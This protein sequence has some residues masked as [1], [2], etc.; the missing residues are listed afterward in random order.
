MLVARSSRSSR[1][2]VAAAAAA[3]ASI[4]FGAVPAAVHAVVVP[5]R[6]NQNSVHIRELGCLRDSET[7]LFSY[8]N[9]NI[10]H[11][12]QCAGECLSLGFDTSGTEAGA[13]CWCAHSADLGDLPMIHESECSTP[14]VDRPSVNC[15]GQWALSAYR[16]PDEPTGTTPAIMGTPTAKPPVS[17]SYSP[18][19][20]STSQDESSTTTTPSP[21]LTIEYLGCVR[22]FDSRVFPI[23]TIF[24]L[25]P[26]D[27][28]D[29]CF[30]LGYDL[31]GT[32]VGHECFCAESSPKTKL[33]FISPDKCDYQCAADPSLMCG[34]T[35]AL[36]VYRHSGTPPPDPRAPGFAL[37][38]ESFY[39]GCLR[40]SA[41]RFLPHESP[42]RNLLPLQCV[43]D[44]FLHDFDIS[45][46]EAGGE[47]WC[48][49]SWELGD[50]PRIDE[51]ECSTPCLDAQD[52]KCGGQWAL[53]AYLWSNK[54]AG[55][56]PAITGTP[57]PTTAVEY[58]GCFRDY[59]SRVFPVQSSFEVTPSQCTELC[60]SMG[61]DL[62]GTEAARECYCAT[63]PPSGSELRLLS[64]DNCN[65]AC[66]AD[67]SIMCGGSWAL[68]VFRHFGTPPDPRKP[69]SADPS[70][71]F[72]ISCLRDSAT[73]LFPFQSPNFHL[74]PLQCV[75]DCASRGFD[76]S[77][78]EAGLECWC[79]KVVELPD[80]PVI[81]ESECSTPCLEE[82]DI[83]CGGQWALAA[84]FFDGLESA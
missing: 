15:G 29:E 76:T 73:R 31:S 3:A 66:W 18:A 6:R 13:E 81:D 9:P 22:D 20:T 75:A 45:G 58:L 69:E 2:A 55:T 63:S 10:L 42:N 74:N 83:T 53:S 16:V 40:D 49:H 61:Y 44:C 41:T 70:R 48:A 11:P 62:S 51:S 5:P 80:F 19:P 27:C 1:L 17:S 64:P 7:R 82:R 65:Y 32:E 52:I 37:K 4:F 56:T 14:C 38:S 25:S 72:Y 67:P 35:W 26:S 59:Y 21:T 43:A 78:T 23:Q 28:A 71:S 36:S 60:F 34:G 30:A 47:C 50:F 46:T 57:T 77:A 12:L 39:I 84:Y 79:A 8:Q 24:N 68:S 33:S 54:P